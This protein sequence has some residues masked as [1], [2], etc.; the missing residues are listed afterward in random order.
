ML[1]IEVEGQ[2]KL[3]AFLSGITNFDVEGTLDQAAA[4]LLANIRRR[5]LGQ[6]DPDGVP[7]QPS[8]A[9][10]IRAQKGRGGGTLFDSGTLFHSIQLFGSQ[11]GERIIGTD[12]PYA[13]F[14][15]YGTQNLIV[16]RFMG[17]SDEDAK[18][19]QKLIELRIAKT[20]EEANA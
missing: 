10:I 3:T 16:R 20:I 19:V 15:Q 12:V 5:F 13:P 17:I 8:L 2:D 18:L 1:T 14:H 9:S 6:V 4:L 11:P 7:W